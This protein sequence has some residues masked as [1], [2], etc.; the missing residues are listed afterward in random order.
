M[1]MPVNGGHGRRIV[2]EPIDVGK[3]SQ[4][5]VSKAAPTRYQKLANAHAGYLQAKAGTRARFTRTGRAA[6]KEAEQPKAKSR[7][8]SKAEERAAK[9]AEPI[10]APIVRETAKPLI[11]TGVAAGTAGGTAGGY[12]GSRTGHKQEL[13]KAFTSAK[14]IAGLR[15]TGRNPFPAFQQG[16]G[17]KALQHK[18]HAEQR[19]DLARRAGNVLLARS[20]RA[21]HAEGRVKNEFQ[22]K[23]SS[24]QSSGVGKGLISALR[25]TKK[26]VPL[27]E[28]PIPAFAVKGGWRDARLDAR[29]AAASDRGRFLAGRVGKAERYYD[30][31]DRRQR[32]FGMAQAAAGIGGAAALAHGGRGAL[33]TT[34][35]VRRNSKITNEKLLRMG[36]KHGMKTNQLAVGPRD[37]AW[38]GGG[39]AGVGAAA[40][41]E[42]HSNHPAGKAW[43]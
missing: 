30:P 29:E 42:H 21:A 26:I 32:H 9:I 14:A 6:A 3:R 40:A 36:S 43:H 38:M 22:P 4:T 31:E 18:F 7:M 13:G 27:P 15:G 19:P 41:M 37:L 10:I 24:Y 20:D 8:R 12:L 1:N 16:P 5:P 34:T 25:G 33:K 39:G 11:Y 35:L 23:L 2:D 17:A 28:R